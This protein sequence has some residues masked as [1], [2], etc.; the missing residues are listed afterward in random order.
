[1]RVPERERDHLIAI[2]MLLYPN[3]RR[4]SHAKCGSANNRASMLLIKDY[5]LQLKQ[6]EFVLIRLI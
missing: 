1:M 3:K 5:S 4:E 2:N 6:F